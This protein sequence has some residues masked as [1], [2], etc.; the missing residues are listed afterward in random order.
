MDRTFF[1]W[2][3]ALTLTLAVLAYT[4]YPLAQIAT[5]QVGQGLVTLVDA[6]GAPIAVGG[7]TQYTE[8]DVDATIS[9]T[10]VMLEGAG[11][12]LVTWLSAA[13]T[14]N[15]ANPTVP[16]VAAF[17]MV[18]DGA[19]WDRATIADGGVGVSGANTTRTVPAQQTI[20]K[21]IDLDES[22]E[23]IKGTAG[24]LCSVWV[25]NTA[26]AT[27]FVKFYNAT[28]ANVTVG[29]TVP[30]ITIGVPGNATDDVSG[31]F[32]TANGCLTFGTAL[33]AAATNLVADNDAT[34][35]GANDIIVM[36]G[37]R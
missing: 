27:R 16:G 29:T 13:L 15:F 3:G 12:T 32:A 37:Y 19:A 30:V 28:A 35:P 23:E 18:W 25:T 21:S 4:A 34:A 26:T 14:D 8:A 10:A 2:L 20:F 33:T 7:G 1:R 24:E 36:V 6:T 5:G 9:G 22:E 17:N 31:S 11:N